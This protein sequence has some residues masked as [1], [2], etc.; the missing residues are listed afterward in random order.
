MDAGRLVTGAVFPG[1]KAGT[2]KAMADRHATE[3]YARF[4]VRLK[5][6]DV[7]RIRH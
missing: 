2:N 5:K 3:E 7:Q 1:Y 6:D 4:L